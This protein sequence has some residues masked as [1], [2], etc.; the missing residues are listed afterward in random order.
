MQKVSNVDEVL[1]CHMSMITSILDDSM[2]TIKILLEQITKIL[3]LC[4]RFCKKISLM[5]DQN[6]ADE[7]IHDKIR[8]ADLKFS[9]L[10]VN[11]LREV[12]EISQNSNK[13]NKVGNIINR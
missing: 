3:N 11:F 1:E 12:S 9:K 7:N 5:Y 13:S 2:L 6:T 10:L 4:L 8:A